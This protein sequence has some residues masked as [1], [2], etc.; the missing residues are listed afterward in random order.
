MRTDPR[1]LDGKRFDLVIIGGGIQG[2]AI[3]REAACRRIATLLVEKTDFAVGTSSRSSRL[4]HG[5]LRYLQQGNIALVKEALH[6]RKRGEFLRGAQGGRD[7]AA[8]E[9]SQ[10]LSGP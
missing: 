10:A 6:E 4:V 3:A 5:G 9:E 8:K 7:S 2:A 1:Q